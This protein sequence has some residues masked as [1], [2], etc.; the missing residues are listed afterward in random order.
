MQ[1]FMGL[2]STTCLNSC[3]ADSVP[4]QNGIMRKTS[5]VGYIR[6]AVKLAMC[7]QL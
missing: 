2:F 6:I 4:C 7:M 1:M 5:D 3:V